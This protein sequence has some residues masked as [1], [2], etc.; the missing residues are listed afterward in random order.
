M[1]EFRKESLEKA[2]SPDNL[3]D[4][5]QVTNPR[6]WTLL[7][8]ITALLIGIIVLACTA[9]MENTMDLTVTIKTYDEN[10]ERTAAEQE[11][12][13][14]GDY[15]SVTAVQPLSMKDTL[16]PGMKLRVVG[17][18]GELLHMYTTP[19]EEPQLGLIFQMEK[20]VLGVP[21]GDYD[22]VLVLESVTPIS[23]L[24]N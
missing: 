8:V 13:P 22:A 7:A 1:V 14:E 19:E 18:E 20:A 17:E 24:L 9:T 2:T 5:L 6:L 21:D 15:T 4:Y 16:S 23:F 3:H 11:N 10:T 12:M